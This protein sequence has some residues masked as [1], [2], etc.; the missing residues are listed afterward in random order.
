MEGKMM[1]DKFMLKNAKE[2]FQTASNIY[3]RRYDLNNEWSQLSHYIENH[4]KVIRR[5]PF[6]YD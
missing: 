2:V 5:E 3:L 6:M 1:N 4:Q